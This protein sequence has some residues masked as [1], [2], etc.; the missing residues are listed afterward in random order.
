MHSCSLSAIIVNW[1]TRDLLH[2][3]LTSLGDEQ[4]IQCEIIVVDNAS[5]DGSSLMV[6]ETFPDVVLIVNERNLG[7]AA[8]SNQ[9]IHASQAKYVIL[10][11]SDTCLPKLALKEMVTFMDYHLDAG[12]M[13]PRLTLV[14]GTPQPYA[15]GRD[16]TLGY[17]FSR[18][19]NQAL[20]HRPMHNWYTDGVQEVDWVS[21]ACLVARR[22]AIEQIGLLDEKFFMY[23]EDND[24][25]LRTRKQGWKIYHNAN[26]SVQH[27]GGQSLLQNAIANKVYYNSLLYFYRKHYGKVPQLMLHICLKIY[28]WG[29]NNGRM[30]CN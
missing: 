24:W 2:H 22:Q 17:L 19:L 18:F 6:Q 28:L 9:G 8:A 4:G 20:F 13:G 23:F 1:N 12:A 30:H 11:N 15:F 10:L 14:D 29:F 3:C 25:C 27:L 26:I 16:P 5:N 21:G 7:F